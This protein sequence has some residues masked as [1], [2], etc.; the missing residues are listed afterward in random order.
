MRISLRRLGFAYV[1]VLSILFHI[2]NI[3]EFIKAILATPGFFIVPYL[4]GF[5][6]FHIVNRFFNVPNLTKDLVSKS[7]VFWFLGVLLLTII[8]II[9]QFFGLYAIIKNFHI[10][11]L[12]TLLITIVTNPKSNTTIS[13]ISNTNG[14]LNHKHK[15]LN[16]ILILIIPTVA[17]IIA[18]S[19]IP[20]QTFGWGWMDSAT[21]YQ[22]AIRSIYEG[23]LNDGRPAGIM[24][25]LSN[26]MIFNLDPTSAMW[27]V[28]IATNLVF[29]IGLYLF[30]Y[31]L[32]KNI[33]IA[34]L[35]EFFGL[36][37]NTF[38]G[39]TG[40][41]IFT[42]IPLSSS[43][44]AAILYGILPILLF[45]VLHYVGNV[46][47]KII[48]NKFLKESI[49]LIF[50][51]F[52]F[53][54]IYF[55]SGNI[56]KLTNITPWDRYYVLVAT[57]LISFLLVLFLNKFL[58][59]FE[60]IKHLL[61][62]SFIIVSVF[63]LFHAE[64]SG[65][66]LTII[67]LSAG[68][69]FIFKNLISNRVYIK[70]ISYIIIFITFMYIF[71]QILG[72]IEIETTNPLS[73]LL[74]GEK[75]EAMYFMDFSV[76][77]KY[78]RYANPIPI[79]EFLFIG[80]F[81][82]AFSKSNYRNLFVL[83]MLSL[84]F[85]IFFF[86]D[87][88]SRKIFKEITPFMAYII[89][90]TVYFFIKF[91]LKFIK[92]EYYNKYFHILLVSLLIVITLASVV[93]PFIERFSSIQNQEYHGTTISYEY[94]AIEWLKENTGENDRIISDYQTMIIMNPLT[95]KVW[96]GD[97]PMMP[98]E[99]SKE[100]YDRMWYIKRN[101]FS[102]NSSREAF[103]SIY[104]M[105]IEPLHPVEKDYVL[106]KKIGN[107]RYIAVITPKTSEWIKREEDIQPLAFPTLGYV[108]QK[109]LSLF[110]DTY[111]FTKLYDIN[112]QVYI[113]GVNPEPGVPFELINNS[114][115]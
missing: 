6:I 7:I 67:F 63:Y 49:F 101:I 99:L 74:F 29:G 34:L 109:H 32:S 97:K 96:I 92:K 57:I 75:Y 20:F 65:V 66:F 39:V 77:Y 25:I 72:I 110:D 28:P 35:C 102:S 87:A 68:V 3:N 46:E 52:M 64:E 103:Y 107:P 51:L 106:Y 42:I 18:K 33:Q 73:K 112:N 79:L 1:I 22:P 40:L 36:F 59:T 81:I 30:G 50:F 76:K 21:Q 17:I 55:L 114:K 16:L 94:D 86:P 41:N 108:N 45:F 14:Y 38:N 78:L 2:I 15:L 104:N 58:F 61:F 19:Y 27:C 83:F 111:Y 71:S 44:P 56:N 100:G 80:C 84:T 23:F 31:I 4:F 48:N 13:D 10:F 113:F 47:T 9:A 37:I 5:G 62:V 91:L 93:T 53:T 82:M 12:F 54:I 89:A 105:G 60:K 24:L 90:F 8:L 95:N 43:H 98:S 26:S 88:F 115:S 85:F 70:Y 69:Y 11:I